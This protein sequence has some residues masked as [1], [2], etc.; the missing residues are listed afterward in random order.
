MKR[1][2]FR[3]ILVI[4][5]IISSERAFATA[6]YGD[7]LI[8]QG[9]TTWINSNPLE[10]YF[11]NKGAR[12]IGDIK[13]QGTCTALWRGYVATWELENDS[14]F[15]VRIQTDYC[16]DNPTEIDLFEEFH[17]KKV[18]ADWVNTTI[19]KPEG[20]LLNYVHMA[21]L[22]IHEGETFYSFTDGVLSKTEKRNYLI[23]DDNL[24]FP[25]K[26]FLRDTIR[27]IIL[28][29]VPLEDR[30]NFNEENSCSIFISFNSNGEIEEIGLNNKEKAET[31]MQK[32]ML[33]KTKEALKNF[34]KLMKVKHELY[35][36]PRVELWFSGHCLKYPF[37]REYGCD[38]E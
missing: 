17:T 12:T 36:P 19:I 8:I 37:D 25:G 31:L 13:M 20:R 35:H 15:L 34:P 38:Y 22:S 23:Q 28:N 9:D 2:V 11:N 32:T 26:D 30:Q 24:I 21:Y 6:Q 7:L 14:L 10:G 5:I 18:F 16:G 33:S 29:A 27:T 4:L 1:K 3:Y